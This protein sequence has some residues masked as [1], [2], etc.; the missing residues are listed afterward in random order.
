MDSY[1]NIIE[2]IRKQL[3]KSTGIVLEMEECAEAHTLPIS[4]PETVK[5]TEI[6]GRLMNV[7]NI[8]EIGTAIGY[9]SIRMAAALGASV[10]T[11]ELSEKLF[12][13]AVGF[14]ELT[15]LPITVLNCDAKEILPTLTGKY[16]MIFIDA[17][18]GQYSA[19][20]KECSRLV[21]DGGVIISDNV[22]YKGMVADNSLVVRRKI[23]IVK[24]LRAYIKMLKNNPDFDTV[25][26][27]VGDG[28]AVSVKRA[29]EKE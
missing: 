5:F 4:L 13:K 19:Y 28:M 21:R 7:N 26:L 23:T 24:R 17:A 9:W 8:L 20:F 18:K 1:D 29:K 27:P 25:V 10:T 16:D 3:P 2:F 14:I 12:N 6:L 22:L 11:I 15:G